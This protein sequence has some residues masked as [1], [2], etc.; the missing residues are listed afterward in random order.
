M[1]SAW[2]RKK[3]HNTFR[4][5]PGPRPKLWYRSQDILLGLTRLARREGMISARL[6]DE[7]AGLPSWGTVANHF[8]SLSNA[9]Q[10]AGLVC[11]G[12]R[13]SGKYGLPLRKCMT[14]SVIRTLKV[15]RDCIDRFPVQDA[16]GLQNGKSAIQQPCKAP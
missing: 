7:D 6:I 10:L 3:D 12:G 5:Q 9:Y 14:P 11:L 15:D 4:P 1:A 8:G 13:G 16:V 2:K